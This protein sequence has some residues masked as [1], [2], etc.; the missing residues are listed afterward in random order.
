MCITISTKTPKKICILKNLISCNLDNKKHHSYRI[1]G[2]FTYIY[3]HSLKKSQPF[4]DRQI[5]QS[6]HGSYGYVKAPTTVNASAI[7]QLIMVKISRDLQGFHTSCRWFFSPD[8]TEP[9]HQQ[10]TLPIPKKKKKKK[11]FHLQESGSSTGFPNRLLDL[12][13]L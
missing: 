7:H 1:R 3:L 11:T 10:R 4:T 8:A 12:E 5:L 2:T 6:S 9:S 13:T